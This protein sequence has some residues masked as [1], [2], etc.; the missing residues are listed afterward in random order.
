MLDVLLCADVEGWREV[1][2]DACRKIDEL[3]WECLSC[4]FDHASHYIIMIW[5]V[6]PCASP[7]YLQYFLSTLTYGLSRTLQMIRWA[8][9]WRLEKCMHNQIA[10]KIFASTK[11][12]RF[13]WQT[14]NWHQ[15]T[16]F[17]AH[18]K[19]VTKCW[20]NPTCCHHFIW[21]YLIYKWCSIC[22]PLVFWL[23]HKYRSSMRKSLQMEMAPK[24]IANAFKLFTSCAHYM[25]SGSLAKCLCKDHIQRLWFESTT[26][27]LIERENLWYETVL[28]ASHA[29]TKDQS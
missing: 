24:A 12:Q 26:E 5:F 23:L 8:V 4:I 25:S 2:S 11:H 16:V 29:S 22:S 19:E 6:V 18:A 21:P 17:Y 10:K 9:T 27:F 7:N 15:D 14:D 13:H 20:R 28:K 1:M 3:V